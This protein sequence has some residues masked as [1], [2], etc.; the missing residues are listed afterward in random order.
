LRPTTSTLRFPTVTSIGSGEYVAT[1]K[2]QPML[3]TL[4]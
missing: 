4:A 2:K 3:G 1:H